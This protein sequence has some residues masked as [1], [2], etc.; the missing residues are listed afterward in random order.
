MIGLNTVNI[1]LGRRRGPMTRYYERIKRQKLNQLAKERG[2]KGDIARSILLIETG[3]E[4]ATRSDQSV[5]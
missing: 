3:E 5:V 2:L 1:R 4:D